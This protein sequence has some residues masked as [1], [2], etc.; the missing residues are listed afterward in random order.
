MK[1]GEGMENKVNGNI[2]TNEQKKCLY[3]CFY[4]CTYVF[5]IDNNVQT[6]IQI[7]AVLVIQVISIV[8]GVNFFI[9]ILDCTFVENNFC[10]CFY[11]V[12][13]SVFSVFL[14]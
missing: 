7:I 10:N 8:Y 2:T 5:V 1:E 3:V 13:R 14:F 6:W 11:H 4:T 12:Y 9:R